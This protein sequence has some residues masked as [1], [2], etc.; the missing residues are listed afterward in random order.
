MIRSDLSVVSEA[1][2]DFDADLGARYGVR[3]GVLADEAEGEVFAPVAMW[4][5]AL[6]LVLGR[7]RDDAGCPLR[8][9]RGISGA[10]Q[11]HGSVFWNASARAALRGLDPA[12]AAGTLREQLAGALAYEFSPNWQD[13]S[14][15][16]ECD[17]FDAHLGSAQRLADVTGSAAH[18]VSLVYVGGGA[19]VAGKRDAEWGYGRGRFPIFF[20][21]LFVSC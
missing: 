4:L 10:C 5:D 8:D 21:F 16:A 11:Q 12:P 3:K 19:A 18:H 15:Q 7:L 17:Q 14:T 20:H 1:R 9:I 2:V 6:E 13:H